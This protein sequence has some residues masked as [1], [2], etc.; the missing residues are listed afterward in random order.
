AKLR[1]LNEQGVTFQS[2]IDGSRFELSPERSIEIQGLLGSD[3]Q[4]QLDECVALPNERT[5]IDKAMRLSIRW[6]ERS[7]RAFESQPKGRAL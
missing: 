7:K 2:H 4:M 6:A 3:I 5:V 1:K